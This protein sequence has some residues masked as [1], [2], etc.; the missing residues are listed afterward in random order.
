MEPDRTG[1][2]P[3]PPCFSVPFVS[4]RTSRDAG[5]RP[6]PVTPKMFCEKGVYNKDSETSERP[7]GEEGS[8]SHSVSLRIQNTDPSE[9]K[10]SP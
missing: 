10:Q 3:Q 1:R 8:E 6:M 5:L 2:S 4:G 9:L 7:E